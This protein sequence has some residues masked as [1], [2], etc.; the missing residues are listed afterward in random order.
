M[1]SLKTVLLCAIALLLAARARADEP[2]YGPPD[3]PTRPGHGELLQPGMGAAPLLVP[4]APLQWPSSETYASPRDPRKPAETTQ[5]DPACAANVPPQFETTVESLLWR[6]ENTDSR[7]MILNPLLGTEV[8]TGDLDL[9]I[10]AGPRVNCAFLAD[11]GIPDIQGIEFGYFGVYDWNHRRLETAPG[12]TFL[13][14]PDRFGDLGATVDFATADEMR[15]WYDVQVNSVELNLLSGRLQAPFS[16]IFGGRFIRLDEHFNLDSFTA[17]RMSFYQVDAR[18]DL[19]GIQGGARW[20]V[21]RGYWTFSPVV[22]IGIYNNNAKQTTLVTDNDRTV[23]LRSFSTELPVAS[24]VLDAG[25]S[26]GYQVSDFWS[27]R[28]GY[29]VFWM[30]NVARA[31]DQLDFS[32]NDMSGSRLFLRDN[33]VAHGLNIGLERRW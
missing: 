17:G 29:N 27:V 32:D 2:T 19:Y 10:H 22:K 26:V 15:V 14:L 6:L 20:N 31:P 3:D 25:I 28:V 23:V 12:A 33:V 30:Y 8:R 4:E 24:S 11:Q 18:N 7:P 16:W 1:H 21:R 9:G 13:R 5:I